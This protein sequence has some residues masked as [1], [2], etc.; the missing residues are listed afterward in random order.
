MLLNVLTFIIVHNSACDKGKFCR[1][2]CMNALADTRVSPVH[3]GHGTQVK[4][5][6]TC[7]CPQ[8]PGPQE[9]PLLRGPLACGMTHTPVLLQGHECGQPGQ[10][11]WA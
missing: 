11:I 7:L 1:H 5:V 3:C 2:P 4:Y 6:Q 9:V 8:P 10:E